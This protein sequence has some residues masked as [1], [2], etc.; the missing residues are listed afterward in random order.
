M[1]RVPLQNR[2]CLSGMTK[3]TASKCRDL[4]QI[5][6]LG[7][8]LC[9]DISA[10]AREKHVLEQKEGTHGIG[11]TSGPCSQGQKLRLRPQ[12]KTT[13]CLVHRDGLHCCVVCT[14]ANCCSCAQV[15]TSGNIDIK[16][17]T[18]TTCSTCACSQ[19]SATCPGVQSCRA[20]TALTLSTSSRFCTEA[21]PF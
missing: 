13:G 9:S 3:F 16:R 19:A 17:G 4:L 15:D 12:E 10:A 2:R 7:G 5:G 21:G 14:A 11:T 20:A 18:T 8:R 1:R 6:Q